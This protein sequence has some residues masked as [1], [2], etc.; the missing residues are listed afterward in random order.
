M[1]EYNGFSDVKGLW[2]EKTVNE[3]RK[4]G[5]VNG[6]TATLFAPNDNLTRAELVQ[7]LA[8]MKGVD[9]STY[10]NKTS[11]FTDVSKNAWYY[12]AVAWA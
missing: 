10:K 11:K 1:E 9:L 7:F 5:I 2:C 6:R 8:N 4:K 3:L 12:A